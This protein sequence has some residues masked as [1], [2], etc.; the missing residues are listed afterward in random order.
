[1]GDNPRKRKA[2]DYHRSRRSTG[3]TRATTAANSS[4]RGR[5]MGRIQGDQRAEE[6][7]RRRIHRKGAQV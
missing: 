2:A 3:R 1:M 5:G 6:M 7:R 4:D